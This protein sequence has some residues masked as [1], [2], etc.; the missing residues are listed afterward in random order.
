MSDAKKPRCVNPNVYEIHELEQRGVFASLIYL[1]QF[2]KPRKIA[3]NCVRH[4]L[5]QNHV[6]HVRW[7]LFQAVPSLFFIYL[8]QFLCENH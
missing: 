6:L 3:N 4:G 5:L 1:S 8:S 2:Y 7:V